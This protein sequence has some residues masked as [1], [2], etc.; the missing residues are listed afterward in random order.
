M[1]SNGLFMLLCNT[2]VYFEAFP[3]TLNPYLSLVRF[4]FRNWHGTTEGDFPVWR[5]CIS[6]LRGGLSPQKA[7]EGTPLLDAASL[8]YLFA[9]V[10]ACLGFRL[11]IHLLNCSW[12]LM[13]HLYY[14]GL[15][16][17]VI[18]YIHLFNK[19]S[20]NQKHFF[21]SAFQVHFERLD[22]VV[23]GQN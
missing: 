19:I 20:L 3:K 16:F 1:S 14:C 2:C 5:H 18:I 12:L 11:F 17:L 21:M 6:K 10:C 9:Q 15:G 8:D 23:K 22:S 13:V 4:Y 7:P